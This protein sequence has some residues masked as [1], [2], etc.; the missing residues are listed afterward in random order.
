M[1]HFNWTN[2]RIIKDMIKIVENKAEKMSARDL[3]LSLYGL[4]LKRQF[5]TE[6]LNRA[7][8]WL[9]LLD[10]NAKDAFSSEFNKFFKWISKIRSDTF[11]I[12]IETD[13]KRFSYDFVFSLR[14][15]SF[16]RWIWRTFGKNYFMVAF[17]YI[18][19]SGISDFSL[20]FAI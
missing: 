14:I 9:I 16:R 7:K 3:I 10:L 20:F 12:R 17:D 8:N 4:S 2:L 6:L 18:K 1:L 5:T 11:K 13:K 15:C 19:R